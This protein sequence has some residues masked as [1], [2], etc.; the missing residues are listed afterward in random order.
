MVIESMTI[1]KEKAKESN[2]FETTSLKDRV[3]AIFVEL[4]ELKE[5]NLSED[6][7]LFEDL[8][9]DSLDA[10]D[11]VIRFQKEFR[12]KPTNQEIQKLTTLGDIY[13]LIDHYASASAVSAASANS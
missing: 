11:M 3:N 12:I 8:G 4:F 7:R 1:E 9:L 10:I 13:S 6:Q 5:D 2:L